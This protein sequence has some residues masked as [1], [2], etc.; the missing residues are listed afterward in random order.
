VCVCATTACVVCA[1]ARVREQ[2]RR[3]RAA[4][5]GGD[6]RGHACAVLRRAVLMALSAS[7]AARPLCNAGVA[8]G[9]VVRDCGGVC[10]SAWARPEAVWCMVMVVV[11]V[12]VV[13]LVL[14]LVAA[15]AVAAVVASGGRV[16]RA[17]IA[18]PRHHEQQL[19]VAL[20]VACGASAA[21][22]CVRHHTH[23]RVC[24]PLGG[25]GASQC[26]AGQGMVR[27]ELCSQVCTLMCTVV[28]SCCEGKRRRQHLRCDWLCG[29]SFAEQQLVSV[30]HTGTLAAQTIQQGSCAGSI[31]AGGAGQVARRRPAP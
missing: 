1:R 2:G 30:T 22:G 4:A 31:Q 12:V 5:C 18:R 9:L 3:R 10:W 23:R 17:C 29:A 11:V 7:G 13:V 21:R 27:R 24:A 8:A 15:A 14:V 26:M 6:R 19:L 20:R 28:D 25:V 16:A